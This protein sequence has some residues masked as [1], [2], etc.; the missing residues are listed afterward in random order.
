MTFLAQFTHFGRFGH[1]LKLFFF[2]QTS[3]KN[4][5]LAK[6]AYFDYFC[7]TCYFDLIG[8]FDPMDYFG[9]M[10]YFD[11][12]NYFGP[13]EYFDPIDYF[14]LLCHFGMVGTHLCTFLSV[15]NWHYFYFDLIC[16]LD[17]YL[18]MMH[19]LPNRACT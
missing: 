11:L 9:L 19:I 5:F 4:D 8:Y 1:F 6:I 7:L 3:P 18:P 10:C 17:T 15:T 14:C 12:L 13:M 2:Y 16:L